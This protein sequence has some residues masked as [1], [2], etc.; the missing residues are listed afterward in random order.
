M[1]NILFILLVLI[2]T[3]LKGQEQKGDT[4]FIKYDEKI[5]TEWKNPNDKITYYTPK[6]KN[7]EEQW[8]FF[9]EKKRIKDLST[10]SNLITLEEIFK[11][12]FM[13]N[14]YRADRLFNYFEKDNH[15]IYFLVR[16]NEF[17]Q[18]YVGYSID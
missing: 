7:N 10:P 4:L 18:V 13:D 8:F 6:A 15:N 9:E 1:K 16:K 5:L 3:T 14:I 17:I 11:E 2:F 12:A